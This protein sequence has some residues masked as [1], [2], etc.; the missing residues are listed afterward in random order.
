MNERRKDWENLQKD[1]HAARLPSPRLQPGGLTDTFEVSIP[2]HTRRMSKS[3]ADA[4]QDVNY[5]VLGYIAGMTARPVE[6]EPSDCP[7]AD[8]AALA[9]RVLETKGEGGP[10]D[11]ELL[12]KAV[13]HLSVALLENRK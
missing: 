3:L 13:L 1:C 12:A 2:G 5:W 8:A 7:L 9:R 11:H 10:D 4:I 6:V